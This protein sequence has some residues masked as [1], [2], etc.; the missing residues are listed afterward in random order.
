M[1]GFTLPNRPVPEHIRRLMEALDL[2]ARE[3]TAIKMDPRTTTFVGC[4]GIDKDEYDETM[5][6]VDAIKSVPNHYAL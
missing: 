6:V 4:G 1:F 2:N 3:G 5:M